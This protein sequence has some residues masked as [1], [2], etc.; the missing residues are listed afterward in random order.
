MKILFAYSLRGGFTFKNPLRSLADIHI[1]I[2]YVAAY[3]KS[4]GHSTRLVLLSS[5]MASRSHALLE[6]VTAA[7][8]PQLIAFTSVS[9]QCPC[10]CAAAAHLK[11]RW[12]EK[13]LVLGG[14]HASLR[15]DEAITGPFDVVCVGEGEL[16]MSELCAQ[17]QSGRKPTGIPN[18][19][20]KQ[21]DG[22]IEKNSTRP[23]ITDLERLP[24]PDREI[25]HDWIMQ[26]RRTHQVVLPSRGC[27]YN[28]SYC[29]NHALRKV[30]GGKYVRM[31]QPDNVLR[32]IQELKRRYPET[33]DIY[34]QSETI[35]IDSDW[36]DD[37]VSKLEAF[38]R[39]LDQPIV[40][41]TNF[42]VARQ[43][44]NDQFFGALERANVRTLEIGLES[45]CERIRKEV[46][47]R[48]YSNAEF[49]EA[50]AL[51]RRHR[52]KVNVYNM[53]GLPGE[54]VADHQE[55]I[56]ANHQVCPN[57]SRTSIFYPYPGTDLFETCKAQGLITDVSN[58]AAE[59]FR[60]TLD[61]PRFPLAEIQRAFDWFEF[62]V[63]R[64]HWSLQHRLRKV[65]RNKAFSHTWSYL[66]FMRLL[67]LWY[68]LRGIK[69]R[70]AK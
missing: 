39:Q 29:S 18:L 44:L 2:S 70:T 11:R 20:I 40:F 60:A 51:A 53:I 10:V 23:Y 24:F 67:P 37:M 69:R 3:L 64:G 59:R 38:N 31:R 50:V 62:R 46:L 13:L 1:G 43:F 68:A 15:P 63:Y 26:P 32:E 16:P 45:G 41:T 56:A 12:P 57:E 19:W 47:R 7:Y 48:H 55:T 33:T 49:F 35:A 14:V 54:S 4:L 52:M 9:T 42:R 17:L 5:E 8:D 21:P 34:L 66:F 30:A 25:W 61:L 28:C 27:P 22:S 58:P 6:G 65:L 36:L